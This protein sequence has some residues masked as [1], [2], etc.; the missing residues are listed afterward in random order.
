MVT[1][2]L[3]VLRVVLGLVLAAHGAQKLFGWFGGL[4]LADFGVMLER[5][6]VRPGWSWAIVSGVVEFVGGLFVVIG[7][8]TPI[9]ALFLAG[10]LLVAILTVHLVHGFWNQDGGFEF[11]VSLLGALV[12]LSLIGPGAASVDAVMHLSLPEPASWLVNVIVVL[13]GVIGAAAVPRLQAASATVQQ[14]ERP[15]APHR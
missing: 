10:N 3:L 5:L 12:A 7:F 8:L 4:G 11:P 15:Q 14:G 13:L 6:G 9:A 2:G 1:T